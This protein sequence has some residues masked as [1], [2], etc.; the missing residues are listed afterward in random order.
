MLGPLVVA[1][2]LAQP[3]PKDCRLAIVVT[4][5]ATQT[6]TYRYVCP[7]HSFVDSSLPPDVVLTKEP[8]ATTAPASVAPRKTFH[9]D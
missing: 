5:N 7:D 8:K 6:T 2:M 4:D 3:V 1:I 9:K